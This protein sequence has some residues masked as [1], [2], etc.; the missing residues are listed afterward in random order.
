MTD[1][2]VYYEDQA[3]TGL[4]ANFGPHRLLCSCVA[5]RLGGAAEARQL[6]T[7]KI[8]LRPCRGVGD[9]VKSLVETAP[10]LLVS[11]TTVFAVFDE[12]KIREQLGLLGGATD[13]DIVAKLRDK[14][15]GDSV[16]I[17]PLDKNTE[18]LLQAVLACL[19]EQDASV[20]T[21]LPKKKPI[22]RDRIL[23]RAADAPRSIRDCVEK[24]VPSF[25]SIVEAIT[26]SVH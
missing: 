2:F 13:A 17:Y 10:N 26:A 14:G 18:T 16:N 19:H 4:T 6:Q 7:D 21:H 9:Q 8:G 1:C 5:D 25:R 3:A 24:R 12:D 15:I 22:E 23:N 20:Q 11:G